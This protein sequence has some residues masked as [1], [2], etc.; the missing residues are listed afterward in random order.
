MASLSDSGAG[1]YLS[2]SDA[3]MTPY[4]LDI[5]RAAVEVARARGFDPKAPI[6]P[7]AVGVPVSTGLSPAEYDDAVSS[8]I[9]ASKFAVLDGQ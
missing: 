1:R 9:A 7:S 3:C 4:E 6:V 2:Y 5:D 8:L